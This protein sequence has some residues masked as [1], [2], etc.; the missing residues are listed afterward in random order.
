[1]ASDGQG[2]TGTTKKEGGMG[3]LV[4]VSTERR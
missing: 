2:I 4:V 1:M 3:S